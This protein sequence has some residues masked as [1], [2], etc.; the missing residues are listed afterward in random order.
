MNRT[1]TRMNGR[2]RNRGFTLVELLV[3]I[4]VITIIVSLGVP[5]YG[6]FT[7]SSALSGRSSDLVSAINYARSEAVTRR[8]T[9]SLE[10][11][12]GSWGNGWQ[13]R[14]VDA[15]T[16]LMT[17]DN[18]GQTRVAL[19]EAA[20]LEGIE[21]DADGRVSADA[22]FVLSTCTA[23]SGDQRRIAVSRFGRV[24][25]TREACP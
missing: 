4:A 12:A 9:V 8:S 22:V 18:R 10:E 25:L 13:V 7:Q 3:T 5:M 24:Q 16:V 23:Y 14:D 21:F 19:A 17:I 20:N 11:L 6:Q 2:A 15:D 1:D